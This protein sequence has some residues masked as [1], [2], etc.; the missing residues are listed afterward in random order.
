MQKHPKNKGGKNNMKKKILWALV[1]LLFAAT[2][3]IV[4]A[5]DW[6]MFH[7][8][9]ALSGVTEATAPDNNNILWTFDTGS[10]IMS[11]PAIVNEK[12]YIGAGDGI[13]YAI[14]AKDSTQLWTYN[15]YS[16]IV[17]SP[18][19]ENGVVYFLAENG[20]I[21]AL[22]SDTG[23]E[24]W[25]VN[26]GNGPYD[27]SSPAIHDGRVFVGSS[28][29]YVYS[30]DATSGV[31]IWK[32]L[33]GGQPNSHI[34]VVNGKV[35]SGTHNFDNNAPTLIALNEADGTV[36]W[37]Y[38]YYLN[39]N[40]IVA[41][42]NHNGVTVADED[43]D[44]NLEVYFGVVTWTGTDDTAICLDEATGT[45]EWTANIGGWSTSTPVAH[46]GK[47]YMGSDDNNLYSLDASTGTVVWK[48]LTGGQ[49]YSAPAVSGDGKI[50]FGSTDHTYY[51]VKESDGSLI[52]KY[53]TGASRVLGSPAIA[54]V[55]C[56]GIVFAG[57]ENG[58]IYAF[59]N[60]DSSCVIE[61]TIDIKPGSYPNSINLGNNGNVPVAILGSPTFDVTTVNP[62]SISLAGAAVN[63]KG[64]AQTPQTSYEDVN[65][66][67]FMDLI[68]HVS[69]ESLVVSEGDTE[70]ILT[71]M[72]Y[73][74]IPISGKDS[75]RI[76]PPV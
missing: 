49:V 37:K 24:L 2:T 53:Y 21:Y 16:S 45:E 51:V 10:Y 75:I 11:S 33:V 42:I 48:Y 6:P 44:G 14:N 8:D 55:D 70:A 71:G 46:N 63:L 19:V 34:T 25:N 68:V 38:D 60:L 20:Y 12:L 13:L 5:A 30:L 72:T 62:Y 18:A 28:T 57:N 32:T 4:S 69:T 39:H 29:G 74:G 3:Q 23:V 1:V 9:L 15:T 40:N 22:N 50:V 41:F 61:V 35:Y 76:V 58:N 26:L 67:G 56:N 27:W 31:Q 64:K 47:L 65:G 54:D 7:H 17:S 66:D 36:A 59:G 43:G 73:D 52:W